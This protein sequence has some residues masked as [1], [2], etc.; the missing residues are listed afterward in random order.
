[1]GNNSRLNELRKRRIAGT[2]KE[3]R[4]LATYVKLRRAEESVTVRL[5]RNMAAAGLTESQFGVLEALH[6]LGSLCQREL[7]G[8]LLK[9]SG[10]ITMVIDN[11]EKRGLVR[12]ERDNADR[13]FV[14]IHLTRGG[15]QTIRHLFPGHTRAVTA[16][17]AALT[18]KEQDTLGRLCRKLGHAAAGGGA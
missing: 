5:V 3:R 10:N 15:A 7:A 13:R 6:H 4:A 8:K 18:P 17:L 9:T 2:E 14:S 11:L 1:M 16:H 12:R